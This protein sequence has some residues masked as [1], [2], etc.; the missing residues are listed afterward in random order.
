MKNNFNQIYVTEVVQNQLKWP[1]WSDSWH[2]FVALLWCKFHNLYF[3]FQYLNH[4]LNKRKNYFGFIKNIYQN[5]FI[6][7]FLWITHIPK[8]S[9][10]D[11]QSNT[12]IIRELLLGWLC[13]APGSGGPSSWPNWFPRKMSL[14]NVT[15]PILWVTGLLSYQAWPKGDL[16]LYLKFKKIEFLFIFILTLSHFLDFFLFEYINF[17][18]FFF[19]IRGSFC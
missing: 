15:K 12:T 7:L 10:L 8:S 14:K 1:K 4:F 18:F 16:V 2:N 3:S 19:T 5:L 17:V 13:R 9:R 6:Y 11:S